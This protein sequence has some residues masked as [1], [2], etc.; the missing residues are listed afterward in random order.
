M[1]LF[2][3]GCCLFIFVVVINLGALIIVFTLSKG[4]V[5]GVALGKPPLLGILIVIVVAKRLDVVIAL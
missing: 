3:V 2:L 4:L 1:C 5:I